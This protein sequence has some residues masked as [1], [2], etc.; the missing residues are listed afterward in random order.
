MS[1]WKLESKYLVP[2]T[3]ST[4]TAKRSPSET[5]SRC[6]ER[7]DQRAYAHTCNPH[8]STPPPACACVLAAAHTC[9]VHTCM[10]GS[11][12]H[13]RSVIALQGRCAR[14]VLIPMFVIIALHGRRTRLAAETAHRFG[15][16]IDDAGDNN[17]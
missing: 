16:A 10:I 2:S 14:H 1:P 4:I 12:A 3:P 11:S 13:M 5:K 15:G 7:Y 8:M 6:E 9:R 17:G